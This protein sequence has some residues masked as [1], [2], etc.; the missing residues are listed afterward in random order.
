M[1]L[2]KCVEFFSKLMEILGND[3]ITQV[4]KELR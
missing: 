3:V 1:I 4:Y 2:M